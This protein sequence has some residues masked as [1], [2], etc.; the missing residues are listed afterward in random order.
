M[1]HNWS[2]RKAIVDLPI[3]LKRNS[4]HISGNLL[5][6]LGVQNKDVIAALQALLIRVRLCQC[7]S[8]YCL[9]G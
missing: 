5:R 2:V 4:K 3:R 6:Q 9:S 1:R 8:G 7:E